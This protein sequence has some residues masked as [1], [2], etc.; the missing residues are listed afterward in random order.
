MIT[1][2]WESVLVIL[3]HDL[4]LKEF[5]IQK[6]WGLVTLR[7][8]LYFPFLAIPGQLQVYSQ[9]LAHFGC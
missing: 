3:I 2:M 6:F 5:F 7:H 8:S 1:A 9:S 4:G